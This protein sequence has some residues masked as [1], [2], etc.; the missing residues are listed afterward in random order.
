MK[1]GH[2]QFLGFSRLTGKKTHT[3]RLQ[4]ISHIE[5]DYNNDISQIYYTFV[6]PLNIPFIYYIDLMYNNYTYTYQV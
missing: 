6:Y 5:L 2:V 3:L 4:S 1:L